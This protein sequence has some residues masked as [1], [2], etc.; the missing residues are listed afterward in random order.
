MAIA[1]PWPVFLVFNE[2]AVDGIAMNVAELLDELGLGEDVEVVIT[3][4]P[5]LRAFGFE[6][7]EVWVLSTR[8]VS[9]SFWCFG[10]LRSRWTC[11]GMRT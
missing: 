11:S 5:E 6:A 4:L 7:A 3:G 8:K 9:S 1:A 10:S 2:A